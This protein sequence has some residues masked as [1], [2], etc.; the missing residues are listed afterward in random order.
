[1]KKRE[2]KKETDSNNNIWEKKRTNIKPD[3]L[4]ISINYEVKKKQINENYDGLGVLSV[5]AMHVCS[6]S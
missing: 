2:R 5:Y 1:M 4:S 3:S 6:S